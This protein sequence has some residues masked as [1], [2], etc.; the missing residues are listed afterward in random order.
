MSAVLL[1]LSTPLVAQT[2]QVPGPT[3][4]WTAGFASTVGEGW[5]VQGFDVGVVRSSRALLRYY[6]L[7]VRLGSFV[8][9]SEIF[10]TQRGFIGGLAL[11]GRTGLLKIAEVGHE[12]SVNHLG[13]DFT[14][15]VGGYL[16]ANSPWPEGSS[17]LSAAALPG[18]RFGRPGGTQAS[19][20]AGPA[21]FV[22][23]ATNVHTFVGLRLEFSLAPR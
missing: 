22:G 18:L 10:G 8:D 12:L 16:A 21:L 17:W 14:V 19:L 20:V 6:S 23:A 4:A 5:Q 7:V 11:G 1:A 13:F 2:V 9:A 3:Q 15:E